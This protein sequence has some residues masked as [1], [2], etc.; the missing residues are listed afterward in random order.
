M[1]YKYKLV[2]GMSEEQQDIYVAKIIFLKIL[3]N[4]KEGSS[5]FFIRETGQQHG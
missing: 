4:F 5:K 1:S 2:S 3:L